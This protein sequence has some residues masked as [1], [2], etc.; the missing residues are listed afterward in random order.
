MCRV[1]CFGQRLHFIGPAPMAVACRHSTSVG[2]RQEGKGDR[3][4]NPTG[5][6]RGFLTP[7][8]WPLFGLPCPAPA[9]YPPPPAEVRSC[10][11]VADQRV[12]PPP[13]VA[14]RGGRAAARP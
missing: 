6:A 9:G 11:R 4:Q 10:G 1:A 13:G 14:A 5:L 3:G 8:S 7:V 12:P 2:G